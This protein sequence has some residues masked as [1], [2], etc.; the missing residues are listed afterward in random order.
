M[1]NHVKLPSIQNVVAGQRCDLQ[2]ARGL[3]YDYIIFK[4]TNVTVADITN[5]KVKVGTKNII[6]VASLSTLDKINKYYGRPETAGYFICWFYRPEM[7]TE[8]ERASFSLGTVDVP[9]LSIHFDLAGTVTSPA[10][11]AY[12]MQRGPAIF[13]T[14]TKLRELPSTYAASG[15]QEISNIPRTGDR[16][17]AIHLFKSDVSNVE[18]EINIGTGP[19]K[20]V[21]MPKGLLEV[22]QSAHGRTPQT[23]SATHIDM[24]LLGKLA[25]F[26]P[27][28]QLQELRVKPTIDSTGTINTVIEYNGGMAGA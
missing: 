26:L 18:M 22:V 17:S 15:A 28:K 5:F 3:T 8:E 2:L 7:A 24:T 12:A 11:E 19:S 23:A 4:L 9:S 20:V 14:V 13:G 21:E 1:R 6:D 10:I 16:I 25:E 27:T